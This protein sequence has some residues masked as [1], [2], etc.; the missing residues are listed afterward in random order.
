MPQTL[1][2]YELIRLSVL[3]KILNHELSRSNYINLYF[4]LK[5]QNMLKYILIFF[6]IGS[7]LSCSDNKTQT[8]S[9]DPLLE[10]I[11]GKDYAKMI[12]IPTTPEGQVDS[13]SM[14][15]IQFE[16]S[17]FLFDTLFEGDKIEHSFSFINVGK[18]DLYI[19]E[20][21]S[22]C[23]CTVSKYSKKAFPPGQSGEIK[24]QFDSKGKNGVQNRKISVITNS[25]PSES[26]L[27][28]TGYVKQLN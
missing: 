25:Y 23:G 7:I 22:S 8:E 11:A 21:N 9:N 2:N 16:S 18:K 17:N 3:I 20:T 24:V 6:V 4:C 19:L 27:I 28:L 14:A 5:L 10:K 1:L 15:K 12:E 26:I 13:N